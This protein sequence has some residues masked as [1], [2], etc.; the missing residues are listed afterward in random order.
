MMARGPAD[1][2]TMGAHTVFMDFQKMNEVQLKDTETFY[3]SII[4]WLSDELGLDVNV[5][6]FWS[7]RR[8]PN[9]N[10]ERFVQ[11]V[12]LPAAGS[13]LIWAMDEVDRLLVNPFSSEFFGLLRNLA[14]C[15]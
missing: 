5:D 3:K 9:A 7:V 11:R 1:R 13:H 8:P 14:Q 12:A 10:L 6:D 15:P 4:Q 2:Q